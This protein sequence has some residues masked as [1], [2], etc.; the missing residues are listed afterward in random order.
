MVGVCIQKIYIP[1]EWRKK[2]HGKKIVFRFDIHSA[3]LVHLP[4][5]A[6]ERFSYKIMDNTFE[7]NKNLCHALKWILFWILAPYRNASRFT[8]QIFATWKYYRN[9]L[10]CPTSIN[11][12]STSFFYLKHFYWAWKWKFSI[13]TAF[14][15]LQLF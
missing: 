10:E 3:Y 2:N 6:D 13:W 14:A 11:W 1:P 5:Y 12:N 9:R 4:V 8:S 15:F 7:C